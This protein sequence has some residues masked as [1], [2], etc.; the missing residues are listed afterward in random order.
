MILVS[1]TG[2]TPQFSQYYSILDIKK[3]LSSYL[4]FNSYILIVEQYLRAGDCQDSKNFKTYRFLKVKK[5]FV[6]L[7]ADVHR[8]I[9]NRAIFIILC[10]Q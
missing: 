4:D 10:I 2:E 7:N 3:S 5:C 1:T 8:Q 6:R 9:V